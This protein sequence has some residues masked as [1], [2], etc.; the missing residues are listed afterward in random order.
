MDD[1]D[2]DTK[3]AIDMRERVLKAVKFHRE[4]ASR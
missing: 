3:R 1:A 2:R 4:I